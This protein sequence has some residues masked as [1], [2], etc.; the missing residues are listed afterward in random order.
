MARKTVEITITDRGTDKSFRITEMSATKLE[1][2]IARAA[3]ILFGKANFAEVQQAVAE[4]GEKGFKDIPFEQVEP[5]YDALLECVEFKAAGIYVK[6]DAA[7]IDAQ[8][9]DVQT[10]FK[11]RAEVLK[12]NLGFFAAAFPSLSR[13]LSGILEGSVQNTPT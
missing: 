5:L 1:K 10:L 2:W 4:A 7:T 12:V 6:V 9:E 11:L 8:V 3:L 13:T